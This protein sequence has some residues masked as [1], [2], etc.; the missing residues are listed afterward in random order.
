MSFWKRLIKA[1]ATETITVSKVK[2][3]Y[4][5]QVDATLFGMNLYS[6]YRKSSAAEKKSARET[7]KLIASEAVIKAAAKKVAKKVAK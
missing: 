4:Q 1:I 7:A 3:K 5:T 6:L 2:G